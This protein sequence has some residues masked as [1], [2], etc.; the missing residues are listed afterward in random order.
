[1]YN[2]ARVQSMHL[3]GVSCV[4][5]QHLSCFSA[6]CLV[7][8]VEK[9]RPWDQ[10]FLR[11]KKIKKRSGLIEA[12]VASA[13]TSPSP[14]DDQPRQLIF[15]QLHRVFAQ[16]REVFGAAIDLRSEWPVLAMFVNNR[17]FLQ[18][19]KVI[20][21]TVCYELTILWGFFALDFWL[22]HPTIPAYFLL[23]GQLIRILSCSPPLIYFWPLLCTLFCP[24]TAQYKS[25]ECGNTIGN[26]PFPQ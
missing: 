11:Q 5:A 21:N 24:H 17:W 26:F 19:G 3:S 14:L 9:W 25:V 7:I 4:P 8:K 2:C 13:K 22:R 18:K 6:V 10:K 1:M 20:L 15:A 16:S 23:C 12:F